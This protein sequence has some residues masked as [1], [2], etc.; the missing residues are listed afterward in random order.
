M[1]E[2]DSGVATEDEVAMPL[3]SYSALNDGSSADRPDSRGAFNERL[4][5]QLRSTNF[6]AERI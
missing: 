2:P 4:C 3:V 6:G 1:V 5:K